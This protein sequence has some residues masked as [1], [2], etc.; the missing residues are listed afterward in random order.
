MLTVEQNAVVF[1]S[2]QNTVVFAAPGSG[3]TTVLTEHIANQVRS[4]R[5]AAGHV[6]AL[7]FTHQSAKDMQSRMGA[8]RLLS[9]D[10]LQALRLG[11]FHAQAFRMLLKRR[12]DIPVLLSPV[13]Q[14]RLMQRAGRSVGQGDTASTRRFLLAYSR[15]QSVWP[16]QLPESEPLR[17]VLSHYQQLKKRHHRWDFDDILQEFLHELETNRSLVDWVDYLLID[18]YQ[19][20]NPLQWAVV[21]AIA[22]AA[23][24][25]VFVVGDDD[26]SIYGFR[27]ASPQ[28]LLTF[29]TAYPEVS[30]RILST[31]FRSTT[32]IVTAAVTLIEHNRERHDKV[33]KINDERA[34]V[35]RAYM[36][37]S[38]E[39]EATAVHQFILA[40][41]TAD[42]RLQVAVLSRTRR[43]LA[44]C[45]R[46]FSSD[47]QRP[48]FRTFHD[49]K[50]KEWDVVHIIGAVV[51][52]PYL[53][54]EDGKTESVL[55]SEEERRLF[56]VAM[57]RAKSELMIHVPAKMDH[58]R[59]QPTPYVQEAGIALTP[60]VTKHR[61]F[62]QKQL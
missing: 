50:G 56:Y 45:W 4:G 20:T 57:T 36:W 17:R 6:L 23:N 35:C 7:T 34:G 48:Q 21:H 15:A 11:T 22:D 32:P 53:A 30:T 31:N 28:G 18:E 8:K 16:L 3:K 5:I 39:E 51:D 61:W 46:L 54:G 55:A 59:Q 1:Q 26:Q 41:W 13:E 60:S 14:F 25:P 38:E 52:N 62:W 49:A 43:Q 58:R 10:Q 47:L 40:T 37:T 27:G 2:A 24:C 42:P 33:I 9:A 29:A 19:D 44:Y 12:P